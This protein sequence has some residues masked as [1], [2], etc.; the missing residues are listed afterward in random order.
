MQVSHEVLLLRNEK[1]LP[2]V[3][4]FFY[5]KG[6]ARTLFTPD[7]ADC[8][9]KLFD[10]SIGDNT[11]ID[12]VE[13]LDKAAHDTNFHSQSELKSVKELEDQP[14]L[15]GHEAGFR[16]ISDEQQTK[17]GKIQQSTQAVMCPLVKDDSGHSPGIQSNI[18]S[19]LS[20]LFQSP[21]YKSSMGKSVE[22]IDVGSKVQDGEDT[23]VVVN[24]SSSECCKKE[25]DEKQTPPKVYK[26]MECL[27]VE[28]PKQHNLPEVKD[29]YSRTTT[30]CVVLQSST[31]T[32]ENVSICENKMSRREGAERKTDICNEKSSLTETKLHSEFNISD[33][34]I[35]FK[36]PLLKRQSLSARK[37]LENSNCGETLPVVNCAKLTTAEDLFS[38]ISPESMSV[39]L[40]ATDS[41]LSCEKSRS[42][43]ENLNQ[44]PLQWQAAS[45]I[46]KYMMAEAVQPTGQMSVELTKQSSYEPSM[47]LPASTLCNANVPAEITAEISHTVY[48]NVTEEHSNIRNIYTESPS[49]TTFSP[50][51]GCDIQSTLCA[52]HV[53]PSLANPLKPVK[54]SPVGSKQIR[55]EFYPAM[56]TTTEIKHTRATDVHKPGL[57]LPRR[58]RFRY[59]TRSQI[60]SLA[61]CTRDVEN[62]C[63]AQQSVIETDQTK[64]P[65]IGSVHIHGMV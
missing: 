19:T 42:L 61:T 11:V 55:T 17:H 21:Q 5:L 24:K 1:H 4:F 15:L 27:T 30:P 13:L 2:V 34:E 23:D 46:N 43:S 37:L 63:T 18:E 38:Q 10:I 64:Q 9:N 53:S 32:R 7:S 22:Q 6:A 28:S 45:D 52:Q 35:T 48:G 39:I 59:P 26:T 14:N 36:M 20:F 44:T 62:S 51:K 40:R 12:A 54:T 56:T 29:F 60:Q 58:Q 25:N 31:V 47:Q 3:K 65:Q 50:T 16:S 49:H 33:S 8:S 41:A 57:R